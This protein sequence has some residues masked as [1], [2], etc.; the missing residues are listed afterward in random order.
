VTSAAE[1][2]LLFLDVDGPLIPFGSLSGRP[3]SA[4][5]EAVPRGL[6]WKTCPLVEGPTAGRSSLGSVPSR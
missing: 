5:A 4:A 6:H 3:R 1:R 2:P